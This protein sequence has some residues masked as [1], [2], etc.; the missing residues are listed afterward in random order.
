MRQELDRRNSL[1]SYSK[2]Q[3]S[4]VLCHHMGLPAQGP[5]QTAQDPTPAVLFSGHSSGHSQSRQSISH[6]IS[7]VILQCWLRNCFCVTWESQLTAGE[8][9]YIW[10]VRI[11]GQP[12]LIFLPSHLDWGFLLQ[13]SSTNFYCQ[14]HTGSCCSSFHHPPFAMLAVSSPSA[15]SW[16]VQVSARAACAGQGGSRARLHVL[17]EGRACAVGVGSSSPHLLRHV[18]RSEMWLCR[19]QAD[20]FCTLL[21]LLQSHWLCCLQAFPHHLLCLGFQPP[22]F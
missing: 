9:S 6:G 22:V 21:P 10:A 1:C 11:Q 16:A 8:G 5:A 14:W 4:V 13:L 18:K 2:G 7:R 17:C 15:P 19:A 20:S 3:Q 12:C